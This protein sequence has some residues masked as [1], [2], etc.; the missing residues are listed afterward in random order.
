MSKQWIM[1]RKKDPF[2]RQAKAEGYNSRATYK[3]IELNER[4]SL[5]SK[6]SRVLDLGASPGGW[7]QFILEIV[8]EK[9][10]VVAVDLIPLSGVKGVEFVQGD[11]EVAS[12]LEE[13]MRFSK[14]YD[15]VLSDAAP[16]LSGNRNL[17]RGRA[18]ALNWAVLKLSVAVLRKGGSCVVKMFRG[19]ELLELKEGFSDR[20]R[21]VEELKPRSSMRSSNEI[22][23]A[24]RGSLGR[25]ED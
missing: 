21:R 4:L 19:D 16:H 9:G 22:Y 25:P 17:D 18:L 10:L 3:L 5:F 8:G 1:A 24:F 2:Y 6:G 20:F 11:I 15:C 7:S 14:E 23:V 12:T 13:V